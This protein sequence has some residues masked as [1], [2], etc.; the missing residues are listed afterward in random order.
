MIILIFKLNFSDGITYN[1]IKKHFPKNL[2]YG[3]IFSDS[4][5][6]GI[7]EDFKKRVLNE[8]TIYT[9][10][11]GKFA[12]DWVLSIFIL[13]TWLGVLAATAAAPDD[14]ATFV[15]PCVV[16]LRKLWAILEKNLDAFE[17]VDMLATS[18]LA[19]WFCCCCCLLFRLTI[20]CESSFGANKLFEVVITKPSSSDVFESVRVFRFSS[21]IKWNRFFLVFDVVLRV[22]MN[23]RQYF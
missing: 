16:K 18:G 4:G 2:S 9:V 11:G 13:T 15:D 7:L 17:L 19:N 20:T 12:F 21:A 22:W 5:C 8:N 6:Y 23:L 10:I 14:A 1:F 3:K